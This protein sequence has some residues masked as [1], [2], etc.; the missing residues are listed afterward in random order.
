MKLVLVPVMFSVAFIA[1]QNRDKIIDVYNSAYPSDPAKSA[2][3]AR[4]AARNQGFNRLDPDDRERCYRAAETVPGSP[5]PTPGAYYAYNPS[6]LP[7]N[8][9]RRQEANQSYGAPVVPQT[10]MARP[11]AAI[12]P[13]TPAPAAQPFTAVHRVVVHHLGPAARRAAD[14][15]QT[16]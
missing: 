5:A 7:G 16:R 2:A 9:I 15:A 6:H 11:A 4:C 3:L 1:F 10:A 12:P 13:S 14:Y 8:D